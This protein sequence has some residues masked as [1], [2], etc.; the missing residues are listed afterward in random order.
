MATSDQ[1]D[2]VV[3]GRGVTVGDSP[4][5]DRPSIVGS[6][7]FE[8]LCVNILDSAG[9]TKCALAL[10]EFVQKQICGMAG[11]GADRKRVQIA[12]ITK[13]GTGTQTNLS[14]NSQVLQ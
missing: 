7:I 10:G 13:S 9:G 12:L 3:S 8:T 2:Q 1:S 5:R 11:A 4:A 6:C 14:H